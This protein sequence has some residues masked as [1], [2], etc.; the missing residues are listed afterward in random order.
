MSHRIL[1]ALLVALG[2]F[3]A[4]SLSVSV[5]PKPEPA[6]AAHSVENTAPTGEAP[7]ALGRAR[8]G[9]AALGGRRT[10]ADF[11]RFADALEGL[12][13]A[14]L[15]ELLAIIERDDAPGLTD[16]M[17][18]VM[19]WW[20]KH[21]KKAASAWA[22]KRLARLAQD[23]PLGYSFTYNGIGQL[24][25]R[26]VR[27]CPEDALAL[28]R[29]YP[30]SGLA[31]ALLTEAN[32]ALGKESTEARLARIRDFP[33]GKP[34]TAMLIK[35]IGEWGLKAP[36]A[37]LDA[38]K[39]F[40]AGDDREKAIGAVLK[41]WPKGEAAAAF[42]H[43]RDAG[44]SD[45]EVLRGIL[46]NGAFQD[47]EIGKQWMAVLSAEQFAAHAPEFIGTWAKRDPA[48]ALSWAVENGVELSYPMNHQ[49]V[50]SH[51]GI[52]SRSGS[53]GGDSTYGKS[54]LGEA[55]LANSQ[56]TLDWLRALPAD[57]RA[58]YT[59]IALIASG[60]AE[61]GIQLYE[62]LP[63]DARAA[64]SGIVASRVHDRVWIESLPAGL[65][66]ENAWRALARNMPEP[67]DLPPGP[68]RDA[69]LAGNMFRSGSV[70]LE[71]SMGLVL[72]IDDPDNR[73]DALEAGMEYFTAGFFA[74]S[75]ADK[76]R[77][78]LEKADL[79]EDWK[80]P[81]V[82]AKPTYQDRTK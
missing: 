18:Y 70:D 25:N 30:R 50:I 78:W 43:Y 71:R 36:Q 11:A 57:Q 60:S 40:P 29:S 26:W 64:A 48:A 21:D 41:S 74:G 7:D 54:P 82:Q 17:S 56:K 75:N 31:L 68:D 61:M 72:K 34:R 4:G 65:A 81:W 8:A 77:A 27:E 49:G 63:P 9:L 37:A 23:G 45:A 32:K 67:I 16:R 5:A 13:S 38:A 47:A 79:P 24:A 12:D 2:G 20:L 10:L 55:L 80:R 6:A 73:R 3:V 42:E 52:A 35:L 59:H 44:L 14:Q 39:A 62:D 1:L 58:K 19:E 66:R 28:A 51:N 76:A 22:V 15:A 69:M 46:K 33:E 53:F